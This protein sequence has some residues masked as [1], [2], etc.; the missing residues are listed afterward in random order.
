MQLLLIAALAAHAS[1]DCQIARDALALA[2]RHG[3]ET[4]AFSELEGRACAPPASCG[5][6]D[7]LLSL[8]R[9]DGLV[10]GPL[11]EIKRV[12][13]VA[14]GSGELPTEW[15]DGQELRSPSGRLSWPS[16]MVARTEAGNWTYPSGMQA[17]RTTGRIAWPSGSQARSS[18]GKWTQPSGIQVGSSASLWGW[19]C[20]RKP[21]VCAKLP[22][23]SAKDTSLLG[24]LI[25]VE[26]GWAAR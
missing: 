22:P 8:A 15:P 6:A 20:D 2:T 14:C 4:T 19:A 26:L 5:D 10:G 13:L 7:I 9:I 23:D 11:T 21:E 25:L 18:S 17:V 24:Q 1:D 12:K 16:G 3:L